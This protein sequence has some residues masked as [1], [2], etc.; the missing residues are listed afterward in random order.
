[1]SEWEDKVDSPTN[2]WYTAVIA[3]TKRWRQILEQRAVVRKCNNRDCPF[4]F[5]GACSIRRCMK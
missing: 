3:A 4:N 1:M 2:D 5:K